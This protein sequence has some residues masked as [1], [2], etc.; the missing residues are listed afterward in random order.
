[1]VWLRPL[2]SSLLLGWYLIQIWE[3]RPSHSRDEFA[4]ASRSSKETIGLPPSSNHRGRKTGKVRRWGDAVLATAYIASDFLVVN[5]DWSNPGWDQRT[6]G[7]P[8]VDEHAGIF[9]FGREVISVDVDAWSWKERGGWNFQTVRFKC[10][11]TRVW[12]KYK[13]MIW[14]WMGEKGWKGTLRRLIRLMAWEIGMSGLLV[15]YWNG[16]FSSSVVLMHLITLTFS[17]RRKPGV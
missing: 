17:R 6:H 14:N 1:M 5:W 15:P 3:R 4:N 12:E 9:P 2:G 10:W 13:T 7:I 11:G 8:P 16:W